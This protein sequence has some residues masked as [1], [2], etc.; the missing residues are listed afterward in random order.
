MVFA[1]TNMRHYSELPLIPRAARRV[2]ALTWNDINFNTQTIMIN[3]SYSYT[4]GDT[5]TYTAQI[6]P[7]KCNEIRRNKLPVVLVNIRKRT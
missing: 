2:F 4:K 6:G 5:D 3:K 7:T 1:A